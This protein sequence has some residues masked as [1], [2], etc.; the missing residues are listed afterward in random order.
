MLTTHIRLLKTILRDLKDEL[1]MMGWSLAERARSRWEPDDQNQSITWH[2]VE[3]TPPVGQIWATDG[4]AVW[5]INS[6]GHPLSSDA[7][8][9]KRWAPFPIPFAPKLSD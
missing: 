8:A 3:E 9:V 7:R 6:D 4:S 2:E 1:D 5:I